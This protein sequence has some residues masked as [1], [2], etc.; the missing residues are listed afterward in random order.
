MSHRIADLPPSTRPRERLARLGPGA[1]NDAELIALV[2][3]SGSAGR[4]AI[5]VADDLLVGAGGV[6]SL[7]KRTAV[8]IA[9]TRSLGAAKAAAVVAAFELGRRAG[10]D[11]PATRAVVRGP[12]DVAA[13]A[14][15]HVRSSVR[16]EVLVV[17]TNVRNRVV[18]VEGLT[19]GTPYRSLVDPKDVLATVFLQ[20]GAGFALV[21]THPSGDAAPSAADVVAT[22][23]VERAATA[24]GV[25]F[26]GHI[27]VAGRTWSEV[28][29]SAGDG[30]P[31]RQG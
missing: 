28:T 21:H 31:L 19:V 30:A 8:E 29:S 1:L 26:L 5:S 11:Q 25:R 2:L 14:R 6:H 24:V 22:E 3:R 18:H 20:R 9:R 27:I 10:A 23:A 16:E 17:V 12:A 13:V 7:S 15:A 4:S